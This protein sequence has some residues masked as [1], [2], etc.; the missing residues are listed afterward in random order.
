MELHPQ[1]RITA[2]VSE[3]RRNV[4]FANSAGQF[5]VFNGRHKNERT[6]TL[7]ISIACT[8]IFKVTLGGIPGTNLKL[9]CTWSRSG[10]LFG[11]HRRADASRA[12]QNTRISVTQLPRF[13]FRYLKQRD[14]RRG[15]SQVKYANLSLNLLNFIR[16]ES[17]VCSARAEFKATAPVS[18]SHI[19]LLIYLYWYSE[20]LQQ[21]K[22]LREMY[23]DGKDNDSCIPSPR[24]DMLVWNRCDP[25]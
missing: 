16:A 4:W 13:V 2:V 18:S 7:V 5:C 9:T 10:L 12:N 14:E 17:K 20:W 6:L 15:H 25:F 21:M 19:N 23:L 1:I 24:S 22:Q 11:S 3:T 8:C